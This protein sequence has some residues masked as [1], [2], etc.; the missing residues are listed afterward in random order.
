MLAK[1]YLTYA[2]N[3][4]A[5]L[6]EEQGEAIEHAAE[7]IAQAIAEGHTLFAF[8]CNHSMLPALDIYYRAGGLILVNPITA[9]GL[10]LDL[11]PPTLTSKMEQL[12]GYAPIALSS[13]PIRAGDVVIIL[14]ASGRN[15]VPV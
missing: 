3:T 12:E 11:H 8:G 14:S 6:I 5:R 9:P 7:T 10:M 2:Q 13:A 1:A 15:A 4:I